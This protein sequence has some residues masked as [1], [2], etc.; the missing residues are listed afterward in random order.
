MSNLSLSVEVF[1]EE[2][3]FDSAKSKF[4]KLLSAIN[5]DLVETEDGEETTFLDFSFDKY[6]D[7]IEDNFETFIK[8]ITKDI[9][10]ILN[11]DSYP[12]VFKVKVLDQELMYGWVVI[13]AG[14]HS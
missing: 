8:F 14:A 13:I 11:Q 1:N 7:L 10:F 4:A 9:E 2:E 12:N 3:T 6:K 5:N